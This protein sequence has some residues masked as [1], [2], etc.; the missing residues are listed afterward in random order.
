MRSGREGGTARSG[1][2]FKADFKGRSAGGSGGVVFD[3][4]CSHGESEMKAARGPRLWRLFRNAAAWALWLG[5]SVPQV[6]ATVPQM[7]KGDI[8]SITA[9][10]GVVGGEPTQT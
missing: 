4:D 6:Q 7:T 10:P 5:C 3:M 1:S 8:L 9:G 2:P